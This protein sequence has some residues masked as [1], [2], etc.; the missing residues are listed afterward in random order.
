M[1]KIAAYLLPAM[2]LALVPALASANVN[3]NTSGLENF[4][5]SAVRILNIVIGLMMTVAVIV[6]IWGLI[7]F[8]FNTAPDGKAT[9]RNYMIYSIVAFAVMT[10]LWALSNFLLDF[11]GINTDN[12][13]INI[14]TVDT[15]GIGN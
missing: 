15:T 1:K 14:P 2:A 8:I 6:F 13:S 9:A 11:F 3:I 7:K 5:Q 12:A 4:V 10:G